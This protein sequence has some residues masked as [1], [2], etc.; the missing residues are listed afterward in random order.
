MLILGLAGD[1][2]LV[3]VALEGAR[4]EPS[5][6]PADARHFAFAVESLAALSEWQQKLSELT[7]PDS[8]LVPCGKTPEQ[9]RAV[10]ER[11]LR[12]RAARAIST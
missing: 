8:A 7:T 2:Q 10:V 9:A 3:L 12:E 6:L 5:A 1:R 4:R 11:H